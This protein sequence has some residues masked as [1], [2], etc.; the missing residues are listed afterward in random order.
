VLQAALIALGFLLP[1]MFFIGLGFLALWVY[2]F[3]TGRRLDARNRQLA[4]LA[5][6]EPTQSES[7]S[8]ESTSPEPTSSE[9]TSSEPTK[10]SP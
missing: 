9:P 4:E 8:P 10:E 5:E 3:V 7:T 6:A 1:L 2:C